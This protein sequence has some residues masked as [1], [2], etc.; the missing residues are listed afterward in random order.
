MLLNIRWDLYSK[1]VVLTRLAEQDRAAYMK[2]GKLVSW[3][4]IFI[5]PQSRK[6]GRDGSCPR[7]LMPGGIKFII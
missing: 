6:G 2:D 4:S 5:L 3:A 1:Q 7:F